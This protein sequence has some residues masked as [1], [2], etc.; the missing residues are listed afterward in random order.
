METTFLRALLVYL[1]RVTSVLLLQSHPELHSTACNGNET[2]TF[3]DSTEV[4]CAPTVHC[5]ECSFGCD[6]SCRRVTQDS[7]LLSLKGVTHLNKNKNS[8]QCY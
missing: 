8:S 2:A 4:I 7:K 3:L 6:W 5:C 1:S